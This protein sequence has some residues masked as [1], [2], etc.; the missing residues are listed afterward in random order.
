MSR[1]MADELFRWGFLEQ[2]LVAQEIAHYFGERYVSQTSAGGLAIASQVLHAFESLVPDRIWVKGENVWRRLPPFASTVDERPV[3]EVA[4]W[5]AQRLYEEGFLG[6][7]FAAKT[8]VHSFGAGLVTVAG[9]RYSIDQRV[10]EALHTLAPESASSTQE[11][12]EVALNWS[13]VSI[14]RVAELTWGWI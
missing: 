4:R 9:P 12:A 6:Q 8:I 11:H 3:L 10:R 1:Y 7:E 2:R 5:M 13:P 14:D